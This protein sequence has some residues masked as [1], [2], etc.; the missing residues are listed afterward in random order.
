MGLLSK[1]ARQLYRPRNAAGVTTATERYP[2]GFARGEMGSQSGVRTDQ[3]LK[4]DEAADY[5]PFPAQM[6]EPTMV[7][8]DDLVAHQRI[9]RD[10]FLDPNRP[11][12][13]ITV[14]VDE[15]GRLIIFDGHHRASRAA[16]TGERE[17]PARVYRGSSE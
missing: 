10:D 4:L 2:F 1:V 9:V 13:P 16:A 12:D 6:A 8:V 3:F 11:N 17:I 7:P 15:N 5:G 14:W